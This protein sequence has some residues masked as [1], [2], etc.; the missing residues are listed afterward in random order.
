MEHNEKRHRSFFGPLLLIGIGLL[1][2]LNNFGWLNVDVWGVIGRFWPLLL[3]AAGLDLLLG[4]RSLVGGLLAL[5]LIGAIAVSALNFGSTASVAQDEAKAQSVAQ[6]AEGAIKAVIKIEAGVSRLQISGYPQTEQ[7]IEGRVFPQRNER[8]SSDFSKTGEIAHYTLKSQGVGILWPNFGANSAGLWE[9]RLSRTVALDL[10]I[11]TGVGNAK[12]D[13]DTLQLTALT[14]NTGVGQTMITLP[15]QGNFSAQIDG[16]VGQVLVLIP[17]TLAARIRANAGIGSVQ[18]QGNF[19]HN[20]KLY[21]SP[22]YET[23]DERVD[24]AVIGGIGSV[25]IRQIKT[26]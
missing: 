9:L 25:T 10:N 7:L 21:I 19:E 23:A 17:D 15:A 18:V 13:L 20:A 2:L 6:S 11:A 1:L 14:I 22:D 12:L 5:L 3:I 16:G 8:I 4:R 24:L 26:E